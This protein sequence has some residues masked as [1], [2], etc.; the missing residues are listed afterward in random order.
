MFHPP[1][2]W[3][4]RADS[5]GTTTTLFILRGFGV[6]E[7]VSEFRSFVEMVIAIMEREMND[8]EGTDGGGI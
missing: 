6:S 2:I 3:D 8:D 7:L 1:P 5:V 4:V